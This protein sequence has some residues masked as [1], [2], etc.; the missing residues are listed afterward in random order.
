M[1]IRTVIGLA[2]A[3]FVVTVGTLYFVVPYWFESDRDRFEKL[4]VGMT[5][6]QV[7]RILM[8]NKPL[9][10][11]DPLQTEYHGLEFGGGSSVDFNSHMTLTF[12]NGRLVEKTWK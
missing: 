7:N 8:P 11:H 5:H 1:S 6:Q 10:N 9:A 3:W 4:Q 2:T 12:K